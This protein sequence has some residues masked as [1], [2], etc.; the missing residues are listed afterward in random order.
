MSEQV[1]LERLQQT[2][3]RSGGGVPVNDGIADAYII[4][5]LLSYVNFS[6][7]ELYAIFID[8]RKPR[9]YNSGINKQGEFIWLL[10]AV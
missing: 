2:R 4:Q 3:P 8:N 1:C 10:L 6:F 9:L 5:A 7:V